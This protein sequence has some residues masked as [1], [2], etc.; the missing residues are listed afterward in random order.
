[1]PSIYLIMRELLQ[2]ERN[3]FCCTIGIMCSKHKSPIVQLSR[4]LV[5]LIVAWVVAV[6]IGVW[7]S[8]PVSAQEVAPGEIH[9]PVLEAMAKGDLGS[10]E[11]S[12]RREMQQFADPTD[13][14]VE[15][16]SQV[17][18]SEEL[19]PDVAFRKRRAQTALATV[20]AAKAWQ[21]EQRNK[22]GSLTGND[23]VFLIVIMLVTGGIVLLLLRYGPQR[24]K[25]VDKT[26]QWVGKKKYENQDD[27]VRQAGA[28]L[29][30][31]LFLGLFGLALFGG[32]WGVMHVVAEVDRRASESSKSR[33]FYDEAKKLMTAA[34]TQKQG[35]SP[36]FQDYDVLGLYSNFLQ[37]TG[38]TK[39][40]NAVAVHA[41]TMKN[42][43]CRVS[44]KRPPK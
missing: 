30:S 38:N 29:F 39:L 15:A 13:P 34:R 2:L 24:P 20:L 21:E 26:I 31:L 8:V 17:V 44:L 37:K 16:P 41:R 33:V 10:A 3:F 43:E 42:R 6:I 7:Q 35:A 27:G 22:A 14:R 32:V 5:G 9:D 19:K 12:A 4:L 11:I 36:A 40:A 28:A 23:I 1:M 25:I 18:P